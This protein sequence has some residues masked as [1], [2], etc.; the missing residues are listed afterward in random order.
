[1]EL[2]EH[3]P[4]V[5]PHRLILGQMEAHGGLARC[6]GNPSLRHSQSGWGRAG[7]A[8][9][10]RGMGELPGWAPVPAGSGVSVLW[11]TSLRH[12]PK[13]RQHRN[14]YTITLAVRLPLPLPVREKRPGTTRT[15]R[16]CLAPLPL[17]GQAEAPDWPR[18]GLLSCTVAG[19][20]T[21]SPQIEAPAPASEEEDSGSR[22]GVRDKDN[23]NGT[24]WC[25]PTGPRNGGSAAKHRAA[26]SAHPSLLPEPGPK[27]I[28]TK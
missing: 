21:T 16:T 15:G 4:K 10:A 3:L 18:W 25:L 20:T 28:K 14:P 27:L 26:F 5:Q 2:L 23:S 8:V 13:G 17:A 7:S 19:G 6:G 9:P 11:D 24:P 1:M 22:P 12:L